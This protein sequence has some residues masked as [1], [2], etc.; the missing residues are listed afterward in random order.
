MSCRKNISCSYCYKKGCWI[1]ID[2]TILPGVTVE[3]GCVIA[4][5]SIVTKST[6][7]NGLY[8]GAPAQRIKDLD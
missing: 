6:Y 5:G 1:C 3:D 2:S 4:A 8:A 7:P